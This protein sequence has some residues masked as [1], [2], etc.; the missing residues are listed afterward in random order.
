MLLPGAHLADRRRDKRISYRGSQGMET[1]VF[2][3]VL[4]ASVD[5][6]TAASIKRTLAKEKVMY[7]TTDLGE[8]IMTS[9]SSIWPPRTSTAMKCCSG[10]ARR[11]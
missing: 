3:R 5:F 7:D 4:I 9:S 1:G 6:F 11:V 10:Y 8:T 2:M